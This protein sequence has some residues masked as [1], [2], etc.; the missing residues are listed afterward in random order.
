M[1][2][3][4]SALTLQARQWFELA[5]SLPGKAGTLSSLLRAASDGPARPPRAPGPG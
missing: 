2:L 1:D 5:R 3:L 4:R